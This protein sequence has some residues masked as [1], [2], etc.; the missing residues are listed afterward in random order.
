[1][2]QKIINKKY[3]ASTLPE[4][5]IA[6][7]ITS[8]CI[9]LAVIIYLNIQQSTLPFIKIKANEL[10]AKYLNE[11][12]QKKEW[13]DSEYAEEEFIIK[14][15]AVSNIGFADCIDVKIT[16]FNA[17]NKKLSQLQTTLYDQ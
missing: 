16:V 5:M 8:F 9:T 14:K 7:A 11:A 15:T 12:I 10:A 1:M 4:V 2:L 3:K 6:L 17:N 13:I